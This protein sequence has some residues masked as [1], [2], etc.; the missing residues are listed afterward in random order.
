MA[1]FEILVDYAGRLIRLTDERWQHILDHA[2]MVGQRERLVETLLTPDTVI[3]T[4]KDE[5]VY[6]YHRLYETTPVTRKYLIVAVKILA[7]D[8]FV[9]TAFYSNRLKKGEVIWQ[10]H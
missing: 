10:P 6:V 3:S 7:E 4:V 1:D 9:I 2:E 5:A 8:A